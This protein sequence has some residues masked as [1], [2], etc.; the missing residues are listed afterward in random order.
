MTIHAAKGLEFSCV[1]VGGMEEGLFPNAMSLNTN[2]E[3]EEERRLFYVAVT[4][5]KKILYLSGAGTRFR[6][7]QLTQNQPS[8]FLFELPLELLNIQTSNT[9]NR[10]SGGFA[11]NFGN[12]SHAVGQSTVS[13]LLKKDLSVNNYTPGSDIVIPEQ[14]LESD[15]SHLK[16][17]DIVQHIKFGTGRVLSVEGRLH[18]RS[19]VIHFSNGG[20]KKIMLSYARLMIIKTDN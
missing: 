11:G 20:E 2:E 13:G 8:R 19:A 10:T 14:F 12:R 5:A 3:L 7:G 16:S 18:N 4:R 17:G 9:F 1:F 6:N 15:T